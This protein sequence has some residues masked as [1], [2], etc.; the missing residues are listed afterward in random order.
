MEE[1]WDMLSEKLWLFWLGGGIRKV[2]ELLLKGIF[3]TINGGGLDFRL[4]IEKTIFGKNVP[5]FLG[6]IFT[7]LLNISLV[8]LLSFIG[9][10]LF[11]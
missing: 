6:D 9:P 2:A 3:S 11:T 8:Y 4:S 7:D 5:L 10:L 1:A